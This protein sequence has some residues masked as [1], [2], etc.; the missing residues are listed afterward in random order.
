LLAKT[1]GEAEILWL[2]A[3]ERY[4][5]AQQDQQNAGTA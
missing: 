2:E 3:S 5:Q 4:E 1:L